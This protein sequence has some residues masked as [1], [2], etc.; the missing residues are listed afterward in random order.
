MQV[1]TKKMISLKNQIIKLMNTEYEKAAKLEMNKVIDESKKQLSKTLFYA[2]PRGERGRGGFGGATPLVLKSSIVKTNKGVKFFVRVQI[3][4][5]STGKL[6]VI[7]HR[8]SSGTNNE[9]AK[10]RMTYRLRKSVRTFKGKLD[11]DPFSGFTD[12]YR[13]VKKGGKLTDIEGRR[14][15]ETA[16]EIIDKNIKVDY[17]EFKRKEGNEK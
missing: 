7:W 1:K 13:S 5:K 15:Y 4:D 9:I 11:V 12:E 8:I 16:I 2:T 3:I 14:F 17:F 6:H 10:R